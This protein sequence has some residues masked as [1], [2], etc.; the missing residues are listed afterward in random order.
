MC[1]SMGLCGV[2]GVCICVCVSMYLPLRNISFENGFS[3]KIRKKAFRD[4]TSSVSLL[5]YTVGEVL[6]PATFS[7]IG[8]VSRSWGWRGFDVWARKLQIRL[9]HE[10]LVATASGVVCVYSVHA[11]GGWSFPS[12]Y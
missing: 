5:P 8:E 12:D 1:V 9:A 7:T 2:V 10:L 6:L 11:P 4:G 3:Q